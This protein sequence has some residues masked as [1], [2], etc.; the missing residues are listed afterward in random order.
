[1]HVHILNKVWEQKWGD[2][3]TNSLPYRGTQISIKLCTGGGADMGSHVDMYTCTDACVHSNQGMC[4]E[5]GWLWQPHNAAQRHPC[6]HQTMHRGGADMGS[7]VEINSCTD[8]FTHSNQGV[9]PQPIG[10]GS[11]NWMWDLQ[12]EV[13]APIGVEISGW[14]WDL[15]S[16][17][18]ATIE[19]ESSY[20]IWDLQ[21]E[22]GSPIRG[23]RS[24]WQSHL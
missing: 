7:K 19:G 14:R 13:G 23:G 1:M 17:V 15:W 5:V 12:L 8:A 2:L 9:W 4:P 22:V 18:G 6:F 21:L 20:Q 16:G 3:D 24:N 11:S 10:G